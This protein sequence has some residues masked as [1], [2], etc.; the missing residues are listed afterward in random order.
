MPW[1]KYVSKETCKSTYT[2]SAAAE[3]WLVNHKW[4]QGH[5][6]MRSGVCCM[7]LSSQPP[8]SLR[9]Q[10][11]AADVWPALWKPCAVAI[12][13][14]CR[15]GAAPSPRM[16]E[17]QPHE[18]KATC[19]HVVRAKRRSW[20]SCWG[21]FQEG[22][23]QGAGFQ[24]HSLLVEWMT[25]LGMAK[26]FPAVSFHKVGRRP[27]CL[28]TALWGKLWVLKAYDISINPLDDVEEWACSDL[29]KKHLSFGVLV[30]SPQW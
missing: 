16:G 24:S 17:W 20:Q 1:G 25:Q 26:L 23:L 19:W 4:D 18:L 6:F 9:P 14:G 2:S 15:D 12:T 13:V 29:P 28:S 5:S 8:Q 11:P 27:T 30:S 21:L 7:R 10:P 22:F 3:E